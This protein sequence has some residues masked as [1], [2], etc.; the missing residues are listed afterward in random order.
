MDIVDHL[1]NALENKSLNNTAIKDLIVYNVSLDELHN[2]ELNE[3]NTNQYIYHYSIIVKEAFEE[4][5][6]TLP[7]ENE[8]G[9]EPPPESDCCQI[10]LKG[11]HETNSLNPLFAVTI[12]KGLQLPYG[13]LNVDQYIILGG[14]DYLFPITVPSP[15]QV[16]ASLTSCEIRSASGISVPPSI[17]NTFNVP[18][19]HV[20]VEFARGFRNPP[21]N[22]FVP[23]CSGSGILRWGSPN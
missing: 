7:N 4:G 19:H 20:K 3:T 6:L 16:V 1:I 9:P 21:L 12:G 17:H 10:R 13:N 15:I 14:P 23:I 18:N 8:S 11:Y 2:W 5:L 22:T